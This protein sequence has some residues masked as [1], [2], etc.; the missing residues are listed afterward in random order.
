MCTLAGQAPQ[1]PQ[2][3]VTLIVRQQPF[4][5]MTVRSRCRCTRSC[6]LSLLFGFI[7]GLSHRLLIS[8]A[9]YSAQQG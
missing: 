3:A 4:C 6:G 8:A 1:L 5:A 9:D 2:R 7:P